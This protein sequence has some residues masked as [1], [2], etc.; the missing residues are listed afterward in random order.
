[1]FFFKAV[2]NNENHDI[3]NTGNATIVTEG[4][5]SRRMKEANKHDVGDLLTQQ[6]GLLT[7]RR[8]E[9]FYE[10][11]WHNTVVRTINSIACQVVMVN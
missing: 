2:K 5:T 6:H 4:L 11:L 8:F 9:G 7:I 3:I 10:D 1:M